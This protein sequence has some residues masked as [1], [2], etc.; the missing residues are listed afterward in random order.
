MVLKNRPFS[1]IEEDVQIPIL[2]PNSLMFGQAGVVPEEEI[3]D[4]DDM[5]LRK[6]AKYVERCSTGRKNISQDCVNATI[7]NTKQETKM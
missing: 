1:Y 6:R 2:T 7:W 5:V 4:I 3:A